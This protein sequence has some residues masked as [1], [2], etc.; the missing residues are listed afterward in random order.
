MTQTTTSAGIAQNPLLGDV[1]AMKRDDVVPYYVSLIKNNASDKDIKATNKKILSKWSSSGLSYIKD[2]AW[3]IVNYENSKPPELVNIVIIGQ[4][5]D[6][7][8]RQIFTT[9]IEQLNICAL[10]VQLSKDGKI[11]VNEETIEGIEWKS[12]VDLRR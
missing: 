4:F 9:K 7:K 2:K 5:S 6:G 10:L 11:K 12:D 1:A 8:N 3:K